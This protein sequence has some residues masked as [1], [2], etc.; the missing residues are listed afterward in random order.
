MPI[1]NIPKRSELGHAITQQEYDEQTVE[2]IEL[3][4]N[5]RA[6]ISSL[7]PVATAGTY[8]SL[9]GKPTLGTAADNAEGDFATAAQGA[10]ADTALQPDMAGRS[11]FD[12]TLPWLDITGTTAVSLDQASHGGRPLRVTGT[13]SSITV[14]RTNGFHCTIYNKSGGALTINPSA[15]NFVHEGVT[16]ATLSLADRRVLFFHSDPDDIIVHGVVG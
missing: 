3:R 6:E 1:L 4:V 12:Y 10:K 14:L 9:T 8:A 5:E 2:Q 11:V 13:P 16:K 15:G 7:A